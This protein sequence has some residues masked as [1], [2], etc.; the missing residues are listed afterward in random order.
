MDRTTEWQGVRM[1]VIRRSDGKYLLGCAYSGPGNPVPYWTYDVKIA[2]RYV[3]PKGAKET[4]ERFQ[5]FRGVVEIDDE[6]VKWLGFLVYGPFGWRIVE[7][8]P[9]HFDPHDYEGNNAPIIG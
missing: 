4:A 6:D 5:G 7:D 8:D 3:T 9:E 2:K 1:I